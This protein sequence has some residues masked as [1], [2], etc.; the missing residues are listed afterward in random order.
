MEIEFIDTSSKYTDSHLKIETTQGQVMTN[1]IMSEKID[2]GSTNKKTWNLTSLK[3]SSIKPLNS[4][5]H[6][7]TFKKIYKSKIKSSKKKILNH[8]K[9][10]VKFN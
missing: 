4:S 8:Q 6:S 2:P 10:P 1:K 7:K 5:H 9:N 3:N